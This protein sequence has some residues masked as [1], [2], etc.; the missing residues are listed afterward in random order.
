MKCKDEAGINKPLGDVILKWL[1]EPLP[2]KASL[3]LLGEFG[4][5]KSFFTYCLTR[6]LSEE[7]CETQ[8]GWI[9]VRFSLRDF[10]TGGNRSST[11]LTPQEFLKQRIELFGANLNG[12]YEIREKHNIL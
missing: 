3:I 2:K 1:H 4:D 10:N 5:G 12:W 7:F 9:T 8:N 6:K 11:Y